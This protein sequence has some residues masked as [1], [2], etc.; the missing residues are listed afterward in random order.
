MLFF[1][2]IFNVFIQLDGIHP[3]PKCGR[4]LGFRLNKEKNTLYLAD[5][6]HGLYEINLDSGFEIIL[7]ICFY[8]KKKFTLFF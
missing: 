8:R 3:L 1:D 6:Y 4:P 2:I 7:F 5:A